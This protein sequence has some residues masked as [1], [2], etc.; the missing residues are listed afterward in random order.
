MPG[1]RIRWDYDQLTSIAKQFDREAEATRQTMTALKR[2][3]EVL[4]SGDWIGTGARAF[5]A[6]MD[7]AVLP[8][9][10]RLA[11]AMDAA[12]KTTL[13]IS[14]IGKATED[15]AARILIRII[16][17]RVLNLGAASGDGAQGGGSGG[18][19]L[20]GV[21][22]FFEGMWEEG[23]GMVSGLVHMAVHPIDTL[24]GLAYGVTHPG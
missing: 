2:Q 6:E 14:E 1:Q 19:F 18:G 15:T 3:M 24:E 13:A 12:A 10:E 21:G 23:K 7:S 22:D 5:Y 16:A 20:S 9:F 11:R 4:Q 17:A 8:A